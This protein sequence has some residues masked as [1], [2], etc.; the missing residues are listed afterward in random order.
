MSTIGFSPSVNKLPQSVKVVLWSYQLDQIEVE[1]HKKII[2]F[3]VLNFGSEEAIRWLFNQYGFAEIEK[4]ADSIPLYQ[5]NKKSLSFW[6][7]VLFINPKDR[8]V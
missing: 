1:K 6:K 8:I 4:I 5:W 3:Q 2:I 7:I